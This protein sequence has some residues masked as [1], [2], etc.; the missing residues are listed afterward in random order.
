MKLVSEFVISKRSESNK[1]K[2]SKKVFRKGRKVERSEE[3]KKIIDSLFTENTKLYETAKK[4]G[5][6]LPEEKARYQEI[7]YELIRLKAI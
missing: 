2:N 6:A 4:R 5:Y 1:S 3:E 7:R